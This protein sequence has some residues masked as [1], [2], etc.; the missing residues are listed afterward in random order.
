MMLSKVQFFSSQRRLFEF[1]NE[2]KFIPIRR[3]SWLA[4]PIKV[5][6]DLLEKYQHVKFSFLKENSLLKFLKIER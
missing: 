1:T 2:K 3:L 4:S 5:T 6:V